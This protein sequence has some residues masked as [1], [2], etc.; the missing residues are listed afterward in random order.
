[1]LTCL[2]VDKIILGEI[3]RTNDKENYIKMRKSIS[4]ANLKKIINEKDFLIAKVA[5]NSKVSLSTINA[6]MNG[7][8]IP[9]LPTLL[10]IA[11]FLNCNLDY[12]LDR[13]N[14]P[15]KINDIEKLNNDTEIQH[16]IQ[17]IVSLPKDKQK[18]VS[19]YVQGIL[20]S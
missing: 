8:K 11:D 10:S 18:L 12:L 13:T 19:A 20:K 7:Q 1:M 14:N 5:S 9:S 4:M 17:S 6:Y 2:L 16:L 15:I 3:M